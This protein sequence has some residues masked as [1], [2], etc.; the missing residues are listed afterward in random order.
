[1]ISSEGARVYRATTEAEAR[2]AAERRDWEVYTRAIGKV[3]AIDY[4]LSGEE[5]LAPATVRLPFPH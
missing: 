1:M 3:T 4:C 5:D 2:A